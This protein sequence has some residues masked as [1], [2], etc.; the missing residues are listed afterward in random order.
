MV[1]K[2]SH[3]DGNLKHVHLS[4]YLSFAS[5]QHTVK[6]CYFKHSGETKNC[7]K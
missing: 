3:N 6:P 2:V 7:L 5:H 4:V 1:V